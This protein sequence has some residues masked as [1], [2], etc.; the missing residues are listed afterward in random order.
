MAYTITIIAMA[1]TT[2]IRSQTIAL[3]ED[4]AVDDNPVVVTPTSLGLVD[5][6]RLVLV[7]AEDGH[8][9]VVDCAQVAPL[10]SAVPHTGGVVDAA[11]AAGRQPDVYPRH[12]V[13]RP[14]HISVG[15]LGDGDRLHARPLVCHRKGDAAA[16]RRAL[17][18]PPVEVLRRPHGA[19]RTLADAGDAAALPQR[20][21]N[22]H[23]VGKRAHPL[24]VHRLEVGARLEELPLWV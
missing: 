2:I 15:Y 17:L 19:C 10:Q 16:G 7:P 18:Q 8:P 21:G 14:L 4:G 9:Q 1:Y 23:V 13:A 24:R 22:Q 3:P 20:V 12:H 5:A 6:C 11:S